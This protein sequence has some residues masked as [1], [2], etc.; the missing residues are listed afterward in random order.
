MGV[1]HV[2]LNCANVTKLRK[3]SQIIMSASKPSLS[4]F[5]FFNVLYLVYCVSFFETFH[6]EG[7][8]NS[9]RLIESCECFSGAF[10]QIFTAPICKITCFGLLLLLCNFFRTK[11][12]LFRSSHQRCSVKKLFLEISQNS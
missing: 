1:F 5:S 7:Q 12:L 3:A 10:P 2:F 9:R 4:N 8:C 11:F 6:T